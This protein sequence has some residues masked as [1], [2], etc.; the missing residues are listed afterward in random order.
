MGYVGIDGCDGCLDKGD[1]RESV[2]D[3][4]EAG[5][6]GKEGSIRVAFSSNRSEFH[7]GC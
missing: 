3:R 7:S 6:F 4:F 2:D 1:V 5:G